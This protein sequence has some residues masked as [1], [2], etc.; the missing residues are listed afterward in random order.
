[1]NASHDSTST[2][3]PRQ[4]TRGTAKPNRPTQVRSNR[5]GQQLKRDP[6]LD[7]IP[8]IDDTSDTHERSLDWPQAEYSADAI[9]R[10]GDLAWAVHH[11][12]KGAAGIEDLL[13]RGS[14]AWCVEAR[15]A[16]TLHSVTATSEEPVT[17]IS[18]SPGDIGAG[19]VHLW[20]GI[21]TVA[22][23]IL[24]P[25]GTAWGDKPISI[26]PGRF[27]ARAAPLR[28]EHQG[29]D[30]MLFISDPDIQPETS[31]SIGVEDIAQDTR[32]VV[33]AR[34][35][36][37]DRLKFDDVALL[38]CWATALAL[39]PAH[40]VF[41]IE[42][43][44]AGQPTVPGSMIGDLILRRLQADHAELALWDNQNSWDPMRAASAFVP[45]LAEMPTNE[46]DE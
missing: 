32:F 23:C 6:L 39:L 40:D 13:N 9:P 37:I 42:P 44:E 20:P 14:A 46:D 22:T 33:R 7:S 30:P 43:N 21:V 16:E 12:L 29:S 27:L 35:D 17:P 4:S 24:D 34:P 38:A 5:T 19:T 26:P 1:M 31:V 15:C 10:P 28:V 11:D 25:T 41:M 36:R 18:L 8:M 2:T 3:P 45:L